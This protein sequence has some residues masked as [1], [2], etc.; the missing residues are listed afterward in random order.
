MKYIATFQGYNESVITTGVY[1][2]QVFDS[3][4]AVNKAILEWIDNTE[5]DAKEIKEIEKTIKIYKLTKV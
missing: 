5:E 4:P 1:P 2:E 3:L